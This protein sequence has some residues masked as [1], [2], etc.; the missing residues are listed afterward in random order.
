MVHPGLPECPILLSHH[1][2][3][4]D[5]DEAYDHGDDMLLM[6]VMV[7]LITL[8]NAGDDQQLQS[9]TLLIR[10]FMTKHPQN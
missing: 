5:G 8:N 3:Q 6:V 2:M 7:N 4:Y 10:A 9:N 1:L